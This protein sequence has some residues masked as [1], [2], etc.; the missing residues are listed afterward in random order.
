MTVKPLPKT[1][2][3]HWGHHK[4]TVRYNPDATDHKRRWE[5][6][7]ELRRTFTYT[8]RA[9]SQEQAKQEGEAALFARAGL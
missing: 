1:E 7:V 8:G 9:A 3:F 5:W 6:K 2:V 4:I